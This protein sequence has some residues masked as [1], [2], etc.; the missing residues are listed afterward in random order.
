MIACLAVRERSL[1][2]PM[3]LNRGI[4]ASTFCE[5]GPKINHELLHPVVST[6]NF[7]VCKTAVHQTVT[8]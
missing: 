5:G 4:V 8:S 1:D 3:T 7:P 2:L 6:R